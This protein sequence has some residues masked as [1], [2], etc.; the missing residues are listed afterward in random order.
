MKASLWIVIVLV[1]GIVGFLIGY[2]TSASTGNRSSLAV[3][4]AGR[5]A[6][7]GSGVR[8]ELAQLRQEVA[9]LRQDF[10]RSRGGAAPAAAEAKPAASSG[11]YGP[12][13]K[14]AAVQPV[15]EKKP[16]APPAAEKKAEAKP[17]E[18]KPPAAGY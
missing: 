9:Q 2:S 14:A 15:A 18:K 8:E 6:A 1:S 13:P 10:A 3:H 5:G 12:A 16:A 17:G 11:G 7:E 4:E